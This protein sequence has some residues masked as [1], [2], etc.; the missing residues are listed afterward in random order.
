MEM[1]QEDSS[2]KF[3]MTKAQFWPVL[4]IKKLISACASIFWYFISFAKP[5]AHLF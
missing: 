1:F 4:S 5:N 3:G 2:Q